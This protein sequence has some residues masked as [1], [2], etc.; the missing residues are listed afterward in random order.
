MNPH[1]PALNNPE[2]IRGALKYMFITAVCC[3]TASAVGPWAFTVCLILKR[4]IMVSLINA[5]IPWSLNI[6]EFLQTSVST[7]AASRKAITW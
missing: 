3:V 5:S 4:S 6:A 7:L 2:D 1:K